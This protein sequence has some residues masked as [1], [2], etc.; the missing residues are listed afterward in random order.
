MPRTRPLSGIVL[1]L[2]AASLLTAGT[3]APP[4]PELNGKVVTY[5]RAKLGKVV[6][7]GSCA[8]L[9]IEALREAGARDEPSFE[10]GGELA[11]GRPVE[12]FK[13]ALPGV[14]LQ[15]HKAVFHGKKAISR[16]HWTTWHHEYPHHTAIVSRVS[17][18]GKTVMVLHQN[19]AVDRKDGGKGDK[20]VLE[21]TLR[22]DSLQEGGWVRIYRPVAA[23]ARPGRPVNPAPGEDDPGRAEPRRTPRD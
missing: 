12:S 18:G 4:L 16:R 7:D 20:S 9:A 13:E 1:S 5:A 15:F 10:A 2:A 14:I 17:E 22:I 21:G 6:G 23:P 19:V 11:W 3:P 8:T